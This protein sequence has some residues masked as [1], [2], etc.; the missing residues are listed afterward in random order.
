MID[1]N[2]PFPTPQPGLRFALSVMKAQAGPTP[3]ATQTEHL[4]WAQHLIDHVKW[5]TKS[6]LLALAM[7]TLA[8]NAEER[9]AFS[10]ALTEID[11]LTKEAAG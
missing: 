5:F 1:L 11:T 3:T 2:K 6:P 9:A 7:W 4:T 10:K 8:T